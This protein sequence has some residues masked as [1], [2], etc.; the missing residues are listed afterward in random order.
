MSLPTFEHVLPYR[1]IGGR[2]PCPALELTVAVGMIEF[3]VV[4]LVDTGAEFSLLDG[5]ML[6]AAGI[7]LLA[8][9]SQTFR[10]FMGARS[11]GHAHRAVLTAAGRAVAME[12][13]FSTMPLERPVLGRDFL[14]YFVVAVRERTQ[15]V[16]VAREPLAPA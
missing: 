12:V 15:E 14:E 9:P 6:R 10:G 11:V 7:D 3:D 16:H 5:S 8:G 2:P 1:R 4:A 13:H